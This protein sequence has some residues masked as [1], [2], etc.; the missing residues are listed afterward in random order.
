MA[1]RHAVEIRPALAFRLD[2]FRRHFARQNVL[3][4]SGREVLRQT[5]FGGF[6]DFLNRH[7][8]RQLV[9]LRIC[10]NLVEREGFE[11]CT[12]QTFAM[13][14]SNHLA[15]YLCHCPDVTPRPLINIAV[16]L[17][18]GYTAKPF[19]WR[20]GELNSSGCAYPRRRVQF[21]TA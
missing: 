15:V 19:W 8:L 18:E 4:L 20:A 6:K 16:F 9:K 10:Y 1:L 17:K 11:P 2:D 3:H 21:Q 14:F 7:I 5:S 13:P 12:R